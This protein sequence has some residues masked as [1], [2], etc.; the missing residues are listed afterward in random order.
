MVLY[1]LCAMIV[2]RDLWLENHSFLTPRGEVP[3]GTQPIS[4]VSLH[5]VTKGHV[6]EIIQ[7][8]GFR[9]RLHC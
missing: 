4:N 6:H 3:A 9:Q 2:A 8:F 7:L 5:F 1:G